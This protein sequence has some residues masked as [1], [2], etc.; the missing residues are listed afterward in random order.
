MGFVDGSRCLPT[1]LECSVQSLRKSIDLAQQNDWIT[2]WY[3]F[4]EEDKTITIDDRVFTVVESLR[5][6]QEF[7]HLLLKEIEQLK[8][9]I[10]E[11]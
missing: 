7:N 3:E 5:Q 11:N 6:Q 4:D 9:V 2:S 1:R 8:K 10:K